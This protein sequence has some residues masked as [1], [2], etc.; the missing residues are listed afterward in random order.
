MGFARAAER[1]LK[2]PSRSFPPEKEVEG[3]CTGRQQTQGDVPGDGKAG[4]R[5]CL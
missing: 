1:R 3:R 2:S 4:L 5:A